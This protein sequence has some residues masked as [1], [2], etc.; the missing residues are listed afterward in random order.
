MDGL[1]FNNNNLMMKGDFQLAISRI[2]YS[3]RYLIFS[4]K[5][6][7]KKPRNQKSLN[8][9]VNVASIQNIPIF[10]KNHFLGILGTIKL[11]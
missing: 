11:H 3:Q 8:I 7:N 9:S 1:K 2:V 4:L 10:A 6:R 5:K